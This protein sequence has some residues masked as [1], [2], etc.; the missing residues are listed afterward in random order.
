[1]RRHHGRSAPESGAS[2]SFWSRRQALKNGGLAAVCAGTM[3]LPSI[4]RAQ[5]PASSPRNRLARVE[6]GKSYF[7]GRAEFRAR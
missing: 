5:K 2:C 3:A 4:A 6:G 1:M 7:L